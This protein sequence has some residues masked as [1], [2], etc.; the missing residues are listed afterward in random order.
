MAATAQEPVGT[1]KRLQGIRDSQRGTVLES[2]RP[3]KLP[4]EKTW[5]LPYPERP[6]K[7]LSPVPI[8]WANKA[9]GV[10]VAMSRPG[11][12]FS[13]KAIWT[14]WPRPLG[15]FGVCLTFAVETARCSPTS[16]PFRPLASSTTYPACHF[17]R[18]IRVHML[19]RARERVKKT[20]SFDHL[21][22]RLCRLRPK[23]L[24]S[25]P[26]GGGGRDPPRMGRAHPARTRHSGA[27]VAST[28]RPWYR[29]HCRQF[30]RESPIL[31]VLCI[32]SPRRIAAR[33]LNIGETAMKRPSLPQDV[34]ILN[35]SPTCWPGCTCF[36]LPKMQRSPL[37]KP[38]RNQDAPLFLEALSAGGRAPLF[39]RPFG[40]CL[41]ILTSQRSTIPWDTRGD[42][43]GRVGRPDRAK[44]PA[45]HV[46][47]RYGGDGH[48]LIRD[49]AEQ[50]QVVARV[51]AQWS[52]AE[53]MLTRKPTLPE[54]SA[55]PVSPCM[56]LR[57]R[58]HYFAW[59]SRDVV[60]IQSSGGKLSVDAQE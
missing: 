55:L 16:T 18:K 9:S 43:A 8:S 15:G 44:V 60:L 6:A 58:G 14:V 24:K 36:R 23:R 47:A 26:R 11:N 32:P 40:W 33:V 37:P 31:A 29:M 20:A 56:A 12:S 50:A 21:G 41:S 19:G 38:D 39:G 59:P 1:P 4:L 28:V 35:T 2:V 54:A 52:R 53:H 27:R 46:V 17:K 45:V 3:R 7:C 49:R 57:F 5:A 10:M 22:H 34:L 51:P 42:I 25:R 48:R 13:R 30:G